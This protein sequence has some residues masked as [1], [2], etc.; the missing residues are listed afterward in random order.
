[1]FDKTDI[2]AAVEAGAI[3]DEGAKRFE[4]FLKA[5]NDPERMLDPENLRFLSNFNDVFLTIGIVVLMTGLGFLSAIS[6]INVLG[7]G[8]LS[9]PQSIA[10][11]RALAGRSARPSRTRDLR[12]SVRDDGHQ[13][14][15]RPPRGVI[16][17]LRQRSGA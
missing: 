11:G 8:A 2:R 9:E 7:L 5:R 6:V 13:H 1:M 3:S 14:A 15:D 16:A 10:E 12:R 4:A 17:R